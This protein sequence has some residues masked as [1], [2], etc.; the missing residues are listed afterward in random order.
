LT[1]SAKPG[2]GKTTLSSIIIEDLN[3]PSVTS[4]LSDQTG[5]TMFYHFVSEIPD[6]CSPSNA[7][8][9][10]LAQL[11]HR[12]QNRTDV[13]DVLSLL[14]G[15][16]STGQIQASD[17][18]IMQSL[19][20]LLSQF[21]GVTLV[22]DGIDECIDS[23]AFLI[24]LQDLCGKTC[25]KALL[26]GRPNI[27]L[28]RPFKKFTQLNLDQT[29]NRKD[30]AQYLR[31]EIESLQKESLISS[32]LSLSK[33]V[34]TLVDRSHGMFLWASLMVRYLNCK[35][36]SPKERRDAIFHVDMIEGIEGLYCTILGTLSRSYTKQREKAKKVF[37]LMTVAR[38]PLKVSE[39]HFALAIQPGKVTDE[40]NFIQNLKETLPIICGALV[41]VSN[42]ETV[43]FIHSSF[44][45]Y[46]SHTGRQLGETT[47]LVDV[48]RVHLEAATTCLSYLLFDV[49]CGPLGGPER[50]ADPLWI[51]KVLF[52]FLEYS[53]FWTHHA[54][55]G[56]GLTK[57]PSET[58]SQDTYSQ[59][60]LL[61]SK[62]L[63][64]GLSISAWIEASWIFK[65]KPDLATLVK[66][67]S[68]QDNIC[69]Q[70]ALHNFPRI[71][72]RINE[73]AAD[74]N[75]LNRQWGHLLVF[76]PSA[77]W[78]SSVT[79][80]A[81]SQFFYETTDTAVS[82]LAPVAVL[83]SPGSMENEVGEHAI[84]VQS[85]VSESGSILGIVL[86]SPSQ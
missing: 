33:V 19:S 69:L 22:V 5:C 58:R 10:V 28:P 52:P 42:D 32:E 39:L 48:G 15:T 65:T 71:V 49:P 54:S 14:H 86:V 57:L 62:F 31:P 7:W 17:D 41:E 47:F 6:S 50:R 13:A 83:Q 46:L 45:D 79:A 24:R 53:L 59:F 70:D 64:Q 35:A 63:Q 29:Y 77:I 4:S 85:K 18:E 84:L 21:S 38:R 27:D 68:S 37:S 76:D 30:I 82:S 72:T 26:L 3:P 81:K 34:S 67:M 25:M 1:I 11:V 43:S 12:Y 73:C 20:L 60:L 55:A 9:A 78:S 36:L 56:I 61:I 51:S 23:A 66:E 40:E 75:C 44:R 74:L 2:F 16:N 80:F 8:K